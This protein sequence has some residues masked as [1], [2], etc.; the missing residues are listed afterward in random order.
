MIRQKQLKL[1]DKFKTFSL[2][3]ETKELLESIDDNVNNTT[4]S[5]VDDKRRAWFREPYPPV[6]LEI[7]TQLRK[8]F[9][10][11]DDNKLVFSLYTPP[12]LVDGKF[13]EKITKIS[14]K[15][16]DIFNRII[17]STVM[18]QVSMGF[19]KSIEEKMVM[20]PWEAY[21]PPPLV[22]SILEY[23]FENKKH[24]HLEARKGFRS[25]RRSKKIEDRHILVFD[26][27]VCEQDMARLGEMLK[28]KQP[29]SL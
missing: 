5:V 14:N 22:G 10:I 24:M 4:A 8:Q 13:K 26:Y 27:L 28:T 12:Q 1:K 15:K 23:S 3:F 18:E 16:E 2:S 7:D 21:Q 19:G 6:V 25:I 11:S 29:P 17:I 9:N 20:K